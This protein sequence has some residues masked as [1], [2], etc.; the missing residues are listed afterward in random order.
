MA[1]TAPTPTPEG[2]AS[3]CPLGDQNA[4]LGLVRD[5]QPLALQRSMSGAA[6][7]SGKVLGQP[8][9]RPAEL[10][11][12]VVPLERT[13]SDKKS[14]GEVDEDK[15]VQ[16]FLTKLLDIA[17]AKELTGTLPRHQFTI[18]KSGPHTEQEL[19]DNFRWLMKDKEG[20]TLQ[21]LKRHWLLGTLHLFK[22]LDDARGK[23]DR[24]FDYLY[25]NLWYDV[26]QRVAL[27]QKDY[28]LGTYPSVRPMVVKL[29]DKLWEVTH[30]RGESPLNFRVE[31]RASTRP[32]A[33]KGD[34]HDWGSSVDMYLLKAGDSMADEDVNPQTG[35]WDFQH[36]VDLLN[37]LKRAAAAVDACWNV[38]YNDSEV[39]REVNTDNLYVKFKGRKHNWHGP[40]RGP[41][42]LKLH[43]HLDVVPKTGTKEE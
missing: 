17:A 6:A 24:D 33:S 20:P 9:V 42:G 15:A 34:Q 32:E 5:G 25:A 16:E 11:E 43:V 31:N 38:Y 41:G 23:K 35:F 37:S 3:T 8:Q 30:V 14:S 13:L 4:I 29:L 1:D 22:F 27:A 2:A 12:L 21:R 39:A 40:G 36:A 19:R 28:V 26:N 7:Q 10:G 18:R